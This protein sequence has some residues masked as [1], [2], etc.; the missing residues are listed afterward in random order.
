MLAFYKQHLVSNTQAKIKYRKHNVDK[1]NRIDRTFRHIQCER[2]Y[3][4]SYVNFGNNYTKWKL[5]GENVF[6]KKI[7]LHYKPT[8]KLMFYIAFLA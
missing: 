7:V 1:E 2:A 4:S 8:T 6:K 3:S 5:N